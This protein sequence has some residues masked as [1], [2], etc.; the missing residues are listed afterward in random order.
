[1][2]LF[3]EIEMYTKFIND[4][5]GFGI[6]DA[7]FQII[8]AV[9]ILVVTAG[10]GIHIWNNFQCGNQCQDAAEAALDIRKYS[11]L[12]SA[13]SEGSQK[14]IHCHIPQGFGISFRSGDVVLEEIDDKCGCLEAREKTLGVEGVHITGDD[15]VGPGYYK[16]KLEFQINMGQ[17]TVE[18]AEVS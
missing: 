9:L 10:I 16:L 14:V 1:M 3:N 6:E 15:L 4:K 5:G 2:K 13:G 8:A 11:K 18:V 17:S 12:V 7:P